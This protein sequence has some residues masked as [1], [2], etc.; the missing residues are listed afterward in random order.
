[1]EIIVLQ[2]LHQFSQ[3]KQYPVHVVGHTLEYCFLLLINLLII[4]Q[5]QHFVQILNFVLISL[6]HSKMLSLFSY[7]NFYR[8]RLLR[9]G[10]MLFLGKGISRHLNVT[11]SYSW[12]QICNIEMS[13]NFTQEDIETM[14][15]INNIPIRILYC[16]LNHFNSHHY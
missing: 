1:M 8:S 16:F 6:L 3:N 12:S 15:L 13:T 14:Q 10:K 7:V 5:N 2:T 4:T 9:Q 11:T